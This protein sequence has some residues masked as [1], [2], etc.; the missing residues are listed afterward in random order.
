MKE[1]QSSAHLVEGPQV[2]RVQELYQ[3]VVA[4]L[5]LNLSVFDS[6]ASTLRGLAI[7]K[8][9]SWN[10]NSRLG[11]ADLCGLNIVR[12]LDFPK[13]FKLP[14]HFRLKKIGKNVT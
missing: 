1:G 12:A 2:Q 11:L 4:G 6:K 5:R 10:L 7:L 8:K 13:Y 3:L 14:F 9:Q